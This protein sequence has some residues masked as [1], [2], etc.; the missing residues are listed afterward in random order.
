MPLSEAPTIVNRPGGV[1]ESSLHRPTKAHNAQHFHVQ[2]QR[3]KKVERW[4]AVKSY[5]R[6]LKEIDEA[7][8]V[9]KVGQPV[10]QQCKAPHMRPRDPR[11]DEGTDLP[12][13]MR[14][15]SAEARRP[16]K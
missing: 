11:L 8:A 10:C 7:N 14:E 12:R 2:Q 15:E 1:Q 16:S 9:R 5:K 3:R 6:A 4:H 13:K